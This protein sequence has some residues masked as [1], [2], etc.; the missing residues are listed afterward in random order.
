MLAGK[1]VRSAFTRWKHS[2]DDVSRVY[3]PSPKKKVTKTISDNEEVDDIISE[4]EDKIIIDNLV[5]KKVSYGEY[6]ES[7]DSG[8]I[9]NDENEEDSK[10]NT[11]DSNEQEKIKQY[12]CPISFCTFSLFGKNQMS[13]LNHIKSNH[14][15]VENKMSFLML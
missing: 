12:L 10:H 6:Y 13:E 8:Q 15:H 3:P 7:N 9:I 4:D 5:K 11:D 14:P 2:S 1:A